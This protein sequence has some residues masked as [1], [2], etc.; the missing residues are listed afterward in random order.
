MSQL[1]GVS[2]LF[3]IRPHESRDKLSTSA[4]VIPFERQMG[5]DLA[6]LPSLSNFTMDS[7]PL[8]SFLTP[9]TKKRKLVSVVP[10][11]PMLADLLAAFGAKRLPMSVSRISAGRMEVDDR[12]LRAAKKVFS[13]AESDVSDATPESPDSSGFETLPESSKTSIKVDDSIESEIEDQLQSEDVIHGTFSQ[14]SVPNM[15]T[16]MT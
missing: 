15:V 12:E 4:G 11:P 8:T 13:Y 6:R 9:P 10:S 5:L 14:F 1:I 7:D 3:G 16:N 2:A